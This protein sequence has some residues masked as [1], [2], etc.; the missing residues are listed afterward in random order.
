MLQ[1]CDGK[2]R[3][4]GQIGRELG[5][6]HVLEG[7]GHRASGKVRVNAQL[8]DARGVTPAGDSAPLA[9]LSALQLFNVGIEHLGALPDSGETAIRVW[10]ILAAGGHTTAGAVEWVADALM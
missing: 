8:I 4:S 6:A 9:G 5:V 7:S 10:R 2:P 3:N 1:Y